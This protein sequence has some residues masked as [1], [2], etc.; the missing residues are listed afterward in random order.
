ME[1]LFNAYV[2]QF[3]G[4]GR[5]KA[6]YWF[7]GIEE[8]GAANVDLLQSRM[9]CWEDFGR[10][11]LMDLKH[12]AL[13]AGFH[14]LF[15][16][17]LLPNL[18]PT[19]RQLIRLLLSHHGVI[20]G[21]PEIGEYQSARWGR[22]ISAPDN[23]LG[24][25]CDLSML[26]LPQTRPW[27]YRGYLE[28]EWLRTHSAYKRQLIEQR[29]T[30]LRGRILANRDTIRWIVFYGFSYQQIFEEM[31][32]IQFGARQPVDLEPLQGVDPGQIS[33]AILD[34]APCLL[35]EHPTS[36]GRT[37]AWRDAYFNAVGRADHLN[38]VQP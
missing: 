21:N 35:T 27:P 16:N 14:N 12:L 8:G 3:F 11:S 24:E 15:P 29:A 38:L 28:L 36:H 9:R 2:N 10:A 34:G 5:W 33:T 7:I 18:Q 25:I 30:S 20:A 31:M 23:L 1:E 13:G 22:Q 19:W 6:P 32:G 4:Y 37:A 26:P 17:G